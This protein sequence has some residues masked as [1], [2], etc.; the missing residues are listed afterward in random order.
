MPPRRTLSFDVLDVIFKRFATHWATIPKLLSPAMPPAHTPDM[1]APSTAHFN[2]LTLVSIPLSCDVEPTMPPA[3]E[4]VPPA[5]IVELPD[6]VQYS[7]L[8]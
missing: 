5:V 3:R 1:V 7:I 2:S 6:T 8:P 4:L